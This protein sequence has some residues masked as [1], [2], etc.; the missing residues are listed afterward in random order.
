MAKQWSLF[1]IAVGGKKREGLR[2]VLVAASPADAWQYEDDAEPVARGI[3]IVEGGKRFFKDANGVRYSLN[4]G[5]EA[6]ECTGA[7]A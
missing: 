5:N 2:F 7:I 6:T 1:R 4:A 3:V